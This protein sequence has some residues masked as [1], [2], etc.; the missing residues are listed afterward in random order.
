MRREIKTEVRRVLCLL[1]LRIRA[2]PTGSGG[3]V[4][5]AFSI[6]KPC[7]DPL[8]IDASKLQSTSRGHFG[9][10]MRRMNWLMA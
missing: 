7:Y 10:R 6:L 1:Q 4:N 2:V 5:V 8:S 3:A 9:S